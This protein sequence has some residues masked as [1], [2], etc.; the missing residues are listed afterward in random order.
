MSL[1]SAPG[2]QFKMLMKRVQDP[3]GVPGRCPGLTLNPRLWR[4]TV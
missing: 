2:I 3:L 1:G 4:Y